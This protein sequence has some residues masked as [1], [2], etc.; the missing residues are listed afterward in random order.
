[1]NGSIYYI[2]PAILAVILIVAIYFSVKHFKGNGGCCGGGGEIREKPNKLTAPKVA[3][4][5]FTSTVCIA[6]TAKTAFSESLIQLMV[7][8]RA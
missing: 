7:L 6:K 8:L 1:M 2:L 3:E 4:K 5:Q